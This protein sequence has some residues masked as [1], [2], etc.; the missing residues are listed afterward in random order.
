[1]SRQC[2]C[3]WN[4]LRG[5][6]CYR[7][8]RNA[9]GRD[10]LHA[11]HQARV[12]GTSQDPRAESRIASVK[13]LVTRVGEVNEELGKLRRAPWATESTVFQGHRSNCY[14]LYKL[15]WNHGCFGY[16][17]CWARIEQSSGLP[18]MRRQR[19]QFA[20]C[21]RQFAISDLLTLRVPYEQMSVRC[22]V[23]KFA[24]RSCSRCREAA[25]LRDSGHVHSSCHPVLQ[26]TSHL[27]CLTTRNSGNRKT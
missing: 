27:F 2:C 25:R 21:G 6:H 7:D 22:I 15:Y 17:S 4:K 3:W 23:G 11:S 1:M 9:S 13:Q 24:S 5:I 18:C 10:A 19:K 16:S 26:L 8:R 20:A 12:C 14:K